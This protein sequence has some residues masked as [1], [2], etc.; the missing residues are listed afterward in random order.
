MCIVLK[1]FG[2]SLVSKTRKVLDIAD[3]SLTLL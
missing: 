2:S 1:Q 3:E